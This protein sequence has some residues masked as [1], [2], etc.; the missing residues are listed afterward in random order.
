MNAPTSRDLAAQVGVNAPITR[1]DIE[2][3]LRQLH[4]GAT[5]T[6]QTAKGVGI[7]VV[8]TVA[9]VAIAAAFLLGRRKGRKQRTF[10]E[11]R[12]V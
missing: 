3:K 11:V 6:A 4:G 2:A 12:R 9:V 7:A 8:A 1:S 5:T 10:V